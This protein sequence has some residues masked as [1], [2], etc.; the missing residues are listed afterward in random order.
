MKSEGSLL[1]ENDLGYSAELCFSRKSLITCLLFFSPPCR[2]GGLTKPDWNKPSLP[3]VTMRTSIRL[4]SCV[5]GTDY[6][7]SPKQKRKQTLRPREWVLCILKTRNYSAKA[8]RRQS[9]WEH[10]IFRCG[11][12]VEN[13]RCQIMALQSSAMHYI[14]YLVAKKGKM[15]KKIA[16]FSS[17]SFGETAR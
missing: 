3:W 9:T 17:A 8:G 12:K 5:Q 10:H 6:H 4:R 1:S 2:E 16:A 13:L 7:Q 14:I 15:E 11:R